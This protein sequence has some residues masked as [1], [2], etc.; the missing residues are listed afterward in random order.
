MTKKPKA[1]KAR[2]DAALV[3]RGLAD[4]LDLARALVMAGKVLAGAGERK[5]EKPSEMIGDDEPLRVKDAQRFV[6]RAGE[7]LLFALEDLGLKET[8]KGLTV[9]DVGCSTGGFTQCCLELG[10]SR[11]LALDVGVN[12][13]A[14]ELRT[15]PRVTVLEKT[16]VREFDPSGHP[17]AD[18][19]VADVSFNSLARL[20]PALRKA[21]PGAHVRFLVMV[22]PQFELPRNL[23]PDGGVVTDDGL[24][25]EAAESVAEAFRALGLVVGAPVE[26]RVAGRSGNREVFIYATSP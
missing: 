13:L 4:T 11:V 1:S 14:W 5:V 26:A 8:L 24:R 10:A 17:P 6:S 25:A 22:K 9:L 12:Q 20:A 16:D 21:A 7:K 3:A 18:M 23:I 19:V 15:N 2:A